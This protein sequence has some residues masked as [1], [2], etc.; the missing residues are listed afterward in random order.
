MNNAKCRIDF[1]IEHFALNIVPL[2]RALCVSVVNSLSA[3]NERDDFQF[4]T[5]TQCS[6]GVFGAGDDFQVQ[7]DGHVGLRDVQLAQ[8]LGYRSTSLDFARFAVYMNRH[9]GTHL[10]FSGVE[11]GSSRTKAVRNCC[12]SSGWNSPYCLL[13]AACMLEFQGI[14]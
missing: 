2:L 13:P 3:A 5:F 6:G 12:T 11:F 14:V 8:Q 9:P 10:D 1:R 4:I 7:F